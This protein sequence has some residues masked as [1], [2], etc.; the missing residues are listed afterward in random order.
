M[1]LIDDDQ[2]ERRV[3]QAFP[4]VRAQGFRSQVDEFVVPALESPQSA[5][6]LVGG[7]R[8]VDRRGPESDVAERIDL[9]LHQADERGEDEHG[10]RHEARGDLEGEGLSGAGGHDADAIASR[11]DRIDDVRLSRP[12]FVVA[13]HVAE[14]GFR[15][16]DA[17]LDH[18][19]QHTMDVRLRLN[20]ISTAGR[21]FT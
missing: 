2:G 15:V 3:T 16:R 11:Q 21:G 12:K 18:R 10:S 20:G 5:P 6:A 9:I 7:E 13:E 14:D 1:R 19:R 8:R 17:G 4:H